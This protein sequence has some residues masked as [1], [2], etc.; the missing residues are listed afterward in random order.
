M[1]FCVAALMGLGCAF[2]ATCVLY[3]VNIHAAQ[4][5][6][7]PSVNVAAGCFVRLSL[8]LLPGFIIDFVVYTR[9]HS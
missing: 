5:T 9:A 1:T 7:G 4:C 3:R 2:Y 6:V 8:R